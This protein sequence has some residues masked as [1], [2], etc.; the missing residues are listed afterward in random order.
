[1]SYGEA[2]AL[3]TA[4][5][6]MFAAGTLPSGWLGDR[7]SR[8]HMMTIFFIGIGVSA[9]LTGLATGPI[10]LAIGLGLVGLFASIYH[11][12]ARRWSCRV[13]RARAGRWASTACTATWAS[14]APR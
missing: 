9:V 6:V 7:W 10:T 3:G 14:P 5:F 4:A 13:L 1:M 11:P 8:A 12:V 2:L